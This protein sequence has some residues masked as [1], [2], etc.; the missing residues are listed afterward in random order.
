MPKTKYLRKKKQ[1]PAPYDKIGSSASKEPAT[2]E[3]EGE[4][5]VCSKCSKSVDEILQCENC[6]CWYCC[7]C[8]NV[9]ENMWMAL[10]QFKAL[11]WFCTE[12]ESAVLNKL[13]TSNSPAAPL[14]EIAKCI[15]SSMELVVNK[16]SE[17]IKASIPTPSLEKVT[18]ST[19]N[20]ESDNGQIPPPQQEVTGA[21]EEYMDR[22]RRKCNLIIRNLPEPKAQS[23]SERASQDINLFKEIV[24]KELKINTSDIEILKAT[25]LGKLSDK[26]R[27]LRISVSNEQ[28]KAGILR[29]A[30]KLKSS[31]K[32][33]SLY[34]SA[35]LTQRESNRQLRAELKCRKENGENNL[36]IRN[37]KIVTVQPRP[38]NQPSVQETEPMEDNTQPSQ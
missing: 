38:T 20:T 12:C 7:T 4:T 2:D 21:I 25:R 8:Q 10:T 1:Q 27:L 34:F 29:A 31:K 3:V 14:E 9:C 24:Y 17:V 30:S 37:G 15:T 22:Q 18:K 36:R 32:W 19:R 26:P 28:S 16:L 5:L 23:K 11:H 13:H 33:S 6:L 35:D